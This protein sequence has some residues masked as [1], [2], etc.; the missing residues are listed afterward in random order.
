MPNS[1]TKLDQF[2]SSFKTEAD[3]RQ[4]LVALLEKLPNTRGVR[5]THGSLEKGKDIVFTSSGPFGSEE[6]VA[7]VV[8]NAPVTGSADSDDG[9]RTVFHQAEQAL[10]TPILNS[11]GEEEFVSKSYIITPYECTLAAIDSIKG[12]LAKPDGVVKFLYGRELYELFENYYPDY[13]VFR[14]GLF[15]SYISDLEKGISNDSAVANLLVRHGLAGQNHDISKIYVQPILEIAVSKYFLT[16]EWPDFSTFPEHIQEQDVISLTHRYQVLGQFLGFISG[17]EDAKAIEDEMHWL[18]NAV[19]SAWKLAYSEYRANKSALGISEKA[20]RQ[21]IALPLPGLEDLNKEFELR[22]TKVKAVFNEFVKH[23]E[24]ANE[25]SG[26]KPQN[27]QDYLRHPKRLD[28]S[29]VQGIAVQM[30]WILDESGLI[31]S[32]VTTTHEELL[33]SADDALV[34]APAGFGKTS[35]CRWNVLNDLKALKD[36]RSDI[37]PVLIPLHELTIENTNTATELFLSSASL[38]GMWAKRRSADG[39]KIHRRFRFYLDGLDEI[40]NTQRQ[41]ILLSLA[42]ELKRLEPTTQLILTGREHVAG[43]YLNGLSRL[44]VAELNE[45]QLNDLFDQWFSTSPDRGIAFRAQIA[46]IPSLKQVMRVPLLATLVLSVYESTSTLPESRVRLYDMFIGL[47]AGGWDVAK[48]VHRDTQF[49]PQPKT[50]VLQYLAGRLHLSERRD[51]TS[52][53][54]SDAVKTLLPALHTRSTALLEEIVHDG[55][56]IPVGGG[57]AFCHLSF[58]EYLAAKD[59]VEP[60]GRRAAEALARYLKGNPWWNEVLSFYVALSGQPKEIELFIRTEALRIARTHFDPQILRRTELLLEQIM[61]AYPGSTP[62]MK[63][64]DWPKTGMIDARSG[65]RFTSRLAK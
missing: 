12:K 44:H 4:A 32:V 45:T 58:Q 53:Q 13:L 25:L 8:K 46:L 61:V 51:L 41:R 21:R 24:N 49:G 35:F 37:V 1:E 6:L 40:P 54:F 15:G 55:L 48:R 17:S 47:M 52:T 34:T 11:R 56:L 29:Y 38:E 59:L 16:V 20:E 30:P 57:Y 3:L 2:S 33:K 5:H 9:A 60:R 7:C 64:Q 19:H 43:T 36:S 10:D 62:N 65:D 23:L 14:S 31:S 22:A 39:K 27:F 42:S 28:Y 50:T 18:G 63:F 26:S